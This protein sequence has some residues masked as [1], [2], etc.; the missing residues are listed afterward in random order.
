M[1]TENVPYRAFLWLE[2]VKLPVSV[3]KPAKQL[4]ATVFQTWSCVL[5][6]HLT[7][8]RVTLKTELDS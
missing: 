2:N 8:L 7:A 5:A 3:G 6:P 1:V 4:I